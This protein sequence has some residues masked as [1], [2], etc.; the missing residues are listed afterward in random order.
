MALVACATQEPPPLD[1]SA[2]GYT[3]CSTV[4]P[5][6]TGLEIAEGELTQ[7]P[8]DGSWLGE[9]V[10]QLAATDED[11]DLSTVTVEVAFRGDAEGSVTLG[12]FETGNRECHS[13]EA[14]S[15]TTR[16]KYPRHGI[17][18]ASTYTFEVSL[19]DAGGF[20]SEPLEVSHTTQEMPI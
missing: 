2:E 4:A 5:V 17:E 10:F 16:I 1:P 3:E 11:Y 18:W 19:T 8:D 13:N 14:I 7:D 20:T 6:L 12:P 15:A 9:L